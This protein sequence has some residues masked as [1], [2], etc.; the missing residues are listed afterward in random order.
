MNSIDLSTQLDR[1]ILVSWIL[2]IP[3]GV[4]LV[5]ILGKLVF[6]LHGVSEFMTLSRYEL[7]PILKDIRQIAER[8]DTLSQK[9]VDAS[10]SLERGIEV[11]SQQAE[12]LKTAA[13][14]T[15]STIG[16]P[17]GSVLRAAWLL[18]QDDRKRKQR[19]K[20]SQLSDD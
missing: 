4:F 18:V 3:I 9:A 7:Y 1:L 2:L 12:R 6:I 14:D 20:K 11:A 15:V 19:R 13:E 5:L 10:E 16:G 8:A 17:I